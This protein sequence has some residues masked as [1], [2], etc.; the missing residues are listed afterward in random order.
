[1][2]KGKG[3]NSRL[4]E[5]AKARGGSNVPPRDVSREVTEEAL[6]D[7]QVKAFQLEG[8]PLTPKLRFHFNQ[9]KQAKREAEAR[10][11]QARDAAKQ[12]ES[13]EKALTQ[14]RAELAPRFGTALTSAV[15]SPGCLVI[16]QILASEKA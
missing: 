3:Q 1:M 13:E 2:V 10:A 16:G 4:A 5:R 7:A 14:L 11:K 12:A 9:R 6:L 15:T 8:R